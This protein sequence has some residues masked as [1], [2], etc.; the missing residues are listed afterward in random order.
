[1]EISLSKETRCSIEDT[2]DARVRIC[3]AIEGGELIDVETGREEETL[4]AEAC[5]TPLFGL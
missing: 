2:G 5:V 3:I 4:A 1:M